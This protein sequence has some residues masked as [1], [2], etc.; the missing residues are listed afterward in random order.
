MAKKQVNLWVVEQYYHGD[1]LTQSWGKPL[2][3]CN[4]EDEAKATWELEANRYIESL[5]TPYVDKD[6]ERMITIR[7]SKNFSPSMDFWYYNTLL[8]NPDDE[9]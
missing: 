4:S 6:I 3:I 9:I 5:E 2:K 8:V 1:D 7:P